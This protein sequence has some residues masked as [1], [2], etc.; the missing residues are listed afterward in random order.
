MPSRR[1]ITCPGIDDLNLFFLHPSFASLTHSSQVKGASY[2]A[3]PDTRQAGFCGP[4][5][6][7]KPLVK[8]RDPK[9]SQASFIHRFDLL[10]RLFDSV[11]GRNPAPLG[12]EKK[13]NG[14]NYLSTG[15]G[16][17]NH[18]Q[19]LRIHGVGV[20][21]IILVPQDIIQSLY[22]PQTKY[23]TLLLSLSNR[24]PILSSASIHPPSY[25]F[26]SRCLVP[27]ISL[28]F[29]FSFMCFFGYHIY[30]VKFIY[31]TTF[32]S[33]TH[34]YLQNPPPECD[35]K[36]TLTGVVY[37]KKSFSFMMKFT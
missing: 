16:F 33:W 9:I 11:D 2:D 8:R 6:Q 10:R 28:E 18:H 24:T 25:L 5:I 32:V 36:S 17:L 20:S 19:Y 29:N 34:T 26:F 13:T 1:A 7:K 22:L 12:M 30:Y 23:T 4:G 37:W 14:I 35:H 21:F 3:R 27:Q 31:I 15:A